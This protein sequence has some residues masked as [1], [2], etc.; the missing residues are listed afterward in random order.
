MEIISIV[1]SGLLLLISPVGAV[2]DQVA[3]DAIRSRLAGAESLEVRVDNGPS[4]QLLQGKVDRVRIAG[5]GISPTPDLRFEVAELETDPIDLA[6]GPLRRGEV[7]LEAPLQ[8]AVRLVLREADVN[9]FLRSPVVTERLSQLRI[10]SL[11]PA[12]ARERDRYA[13]NNPTVEF[14]ASESG[15]ESADKVLSK[16]LSESPAGQPD[17][18]AAL[19]PAAGRVKLSVELVDLV[20]PGSLQIEI[21]SGLGVNG[22]DRL[23]LVEPAIL[24]NGQKAPRRLI[25]TLLGTLNGQLSFQSL[26]QRGITARALHLSTDPEQ[27]ELALWVRL[28]PSLTASQD[29]EN[30]EEGAEKGP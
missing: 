5:R 12:Q 3:A 18:A 6:F 9:A 7:V 14:L 8:G 23:S 2:L 28:D 15:D 24:V 10:D 4:F 20:Q 22:G 13:L 27:L 25:E 16:V 21:V 30:A 19:S 17:E 29:A 11:A 1:L 26:E